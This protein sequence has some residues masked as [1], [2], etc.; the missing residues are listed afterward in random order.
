VGYAFAQWLEITGAR[1]TEAVEIHRTKRRGRTEIR[2]EGLDLPGGGDYDLIF[3]LKADGRIADVRRLLIRETLSSV[4]EAVARFVERFVWVYDTGSASLLRD[5]LYPTYITLR[6]RGYPTT[7]ESIGHLREDFSAPLPVASMSWERSEGRAT[8]A[9]SPAPES[10]TPV[11]LTVDIPRYIAARGPEPYEKMEALRDSL[12]RWS[13][14]RPIRDPHSPQ[15]RRTIEMLSEKHGMIALQEDV[16][17]GY[18]VVLLDSARYVIEASLPPF[19][20]LIPAIL[21]YRPIEACSLGG[22]VVANISPNSLD[23]LYYTPQGIQITGYAV[24]KKPS[25]ASHHFTRIREVY[26]LGN[27]GNPR[28]TRVWMD[29]VPFVRTDV[30]ADLFAAPEGVK[31]G[32]Q[33]FQ[34]RIH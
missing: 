34:I 33:R 23:S 26:A 13:E 1:L 30:L 17:R 24:W 22:V 25:E 29:L 12:K 21:R 14:R 16:F 18:R 10:D 7:E 28:V 27:D 15:G 32:R 6:Y 9:L 19:Q 2:V 20:G 3:E 5:F 31:P 8:V 4:D 11:I